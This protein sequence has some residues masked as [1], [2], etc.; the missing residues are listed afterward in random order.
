MVRAMICPEYMACILAKGH[1][2]MTTPYPQGCWR[3][4]VNGE[5]LNILVVA[6]GL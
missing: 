1:T 6:N 3:R 5:L 4:I 2:E